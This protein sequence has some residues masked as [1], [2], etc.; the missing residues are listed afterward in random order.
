VTVIA[1]FAVVP[2]GTTEVGLDKA[3]T[4]AVQTVK[5]SCAKQEM[6]WELTSMGTI[7]EGPSLSIVLGI[8]MEAIE[9]VFQQGNSRVSTSIKIDDRRDI[10]GLRKAKKVDVVQ[11]QLK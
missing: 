5:D 4:A 10:Q 2:L 11:S 8:I 6:K 1:E 3:V 9:A 7:I